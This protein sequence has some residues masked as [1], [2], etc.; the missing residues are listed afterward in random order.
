MT[1]KSKTDFV[2]DFNL[3]KLGVV[4][5][6]T[7]L[8]KQ[9]LN[10]NQIQGKITIYNSEFILA[11]KAEISYKFLVIFLSVSSKFENCQYSSRKF[12]LSV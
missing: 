7:E 3:R 10:E 11:L 1:Y 12:F 4:E 9:G 2:K 6:C 8:Q 5:Y